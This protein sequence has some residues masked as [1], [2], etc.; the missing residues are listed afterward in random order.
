M[1][2]RTTTEVFITTRFAAAHRWKDAPDKYPLLKNFHRHEF[3]V[4]LWKKVSHDNRD[5]EFVDLKHQV[6][7][8]I[9][10]NWEGRSLELS[11]EQFAGRLMLAFGASA[12]E[13]SEDGENGAIVHAEEVVE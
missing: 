2:I 12:I 7:D 6:I 11:C 9:R 8:F 1:T 4:K 13:V 5:I 3:H 10:S